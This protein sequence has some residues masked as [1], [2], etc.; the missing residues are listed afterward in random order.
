MFLLLSVWDYVCAALCII[1]PQ[2]KP[3]GVDLPI[4]VQNRILWMA[5]HADHQDRLTW[6]HKELKTLQVCRLTDWL[7]VPK[8]FARFHSPW[9]MVCN[10]NEC[11]PEP[12]CHWSLLYGNKHSS[13]EFTVLETKL[14]CIRDSFDCYEEGRYRQFVETY[15]PIFRDVLQDTVSFII[16]PM[17]VWLPTSRY[18]FNHK[19]NLSPNASFASVSLAHVMF[20]EACIET[21]RVLRFRHP[22]AIR[23]EHEAVKRYEARK[24]AES[25]QE[26]Q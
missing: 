8:P 14:Q 22:R 3:F 4:E 15:L 10:C 25:Q 6:V 1:D 12:D 16:L 26:E 18:Q 5:W 23:E 2:D 11:D 20:I 24:K 21:A 19:R 13:V 17:L 9:K 7:R